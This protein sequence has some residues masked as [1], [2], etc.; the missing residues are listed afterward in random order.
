MKL[1][2]S[3]NLILLVILTSCNY[4]KN[5]SKLELQ[6]QATLDQNAQQF[7]NEKNLISNTTKDLLSA[8]NNNWISVNYKTGDTIARGEQI[9]TK[10]YNYHQNNT[11]TIINNKNLDGVFML[12]ELKPKDKTYEEYSKNFKLTH[13]FFIKSKE[14]YTINNISSARYVVHGNLGHNWKEKITKYLSSLIP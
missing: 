13:S 9:S 6:Y 11:L 2:I 8:S 10:N 4:K 12:S 7:N 1:I 3:L 5:V 14:Q